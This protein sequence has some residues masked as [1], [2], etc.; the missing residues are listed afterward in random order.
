[1][2]KRKIANQSVFHIEE[3]VLDPVF[4]RSDPTVKQEVSRKEKQGANVD[5][6]RLKLSNRV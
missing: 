2:V 3:I 6:I 4:L 5:V 1:M